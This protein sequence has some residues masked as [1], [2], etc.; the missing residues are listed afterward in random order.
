MSKMFRDRDRIKLRRNVIVETPSP[1]SMCISYLLLH[2]NIIIPPTEQLK[3]THIYCLTVSDRG[4]GSD[5]GLAGFPTS[6]FYKAAIKMSARSVISSDDL[7][8]EEATSKFMRLSAGFRLLWAVRLTS[9]VS[10]WLL[11]PLS[12]QLFVGQEPLSDLCSWAFTTYSLA[13][14]KPEI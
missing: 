5:H 3:I 12:S 10:C 7:T 2:N 6:E 8:G 1:K 13:S 4:S 14:S 11:V 9:S